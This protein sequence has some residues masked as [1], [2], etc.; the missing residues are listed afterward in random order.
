MKETGK[1]VDGM[2]ISSAQKKIRESSK[3]RLAVMEKL[4]LDLF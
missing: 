2:S 1:L 4:T 3:A